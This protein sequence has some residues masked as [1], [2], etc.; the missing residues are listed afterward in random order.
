MK[1]KRANFNVCPFIV[2]KK[3]GVPLYTHNY[4]NIFFETKIEH[5][6][7]PFITNISGLV[8]TII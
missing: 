3:E 7:Y 2:A 5:L 6:R 8:S 4:E 1:T